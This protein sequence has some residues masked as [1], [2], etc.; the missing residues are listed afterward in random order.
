MDALKAQLTKIQQQLSGLTASQKMLTA[1]LA[2]YVCR[3]GGIPHLT[4][5]LSAP[6]GRRGDPPL[7]REILGVR[8]EHDNGAG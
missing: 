4:L 3:V 2:V 7:D 6:A 8:V 1:A 5:S